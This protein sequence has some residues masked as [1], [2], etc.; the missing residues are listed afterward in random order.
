LERLDRGRLAH[1]VDAFPR[2][3]YFL[4]QLF[5]ERSRH[6]M[7][8]LANLLSPGEH[9]HPRFKNPLHE[10]TVPFIGQVTGGA[11]SLPASSAIG[12][13]RGRAARATENNIVT[14]PMKRLRGKTLWDETGTS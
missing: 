9:A 8:K 3:Q 7:S 10:V 1:G 11:G 13:Q 12:E 5:S 6:R 2:H 4:E 14:G